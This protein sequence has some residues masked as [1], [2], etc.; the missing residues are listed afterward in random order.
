MR[1]GHARLTSRNIGYHS[2]REHG[3]RL[4]GTADDDLVAVGVGEDQDSRGRHLLR[5]TV[6]N[7]RRGQTSRQSVQVRLVEH[8]SR[9]S[10]PFCVPPHLDPEGLPEVPLE[11][12]VH[13]TGVRGAAE[14]RGV[15]LFGKLQVADDGLCED[16]TEGHARFD[17]L[18]TLDS[19]VDAPSSIG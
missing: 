1:D 16:T 13:R 19:S 4:S 14:E 8:Q 17:R 5:P 3:K 12:P 15:P 18:A 6:G 9:T 10:G 7:A 11:Q 2:A